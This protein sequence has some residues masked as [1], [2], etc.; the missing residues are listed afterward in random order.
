MNTRPVASSPLLWRSSCSNQLVAAQAMLF[1]QSRHGPPLQAPGVARVALRA[2]T[3]AVLAG[4]RLRIA[5]TAQI[6]GVMGFVLARGV[7]RGTE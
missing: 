4:P 6:G 3:G 1:G 7:V 5:N 2:V